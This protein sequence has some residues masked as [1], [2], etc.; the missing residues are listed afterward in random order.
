MAKQS[1]GAK[2]LAVLRMD[3]DNLG[4]LFISGLGHERRTFS[5][6]SV[7]SRN[8][9][10]FF[11]G[12]LNHLWSTRYNNSAYIIY[13]GG[14]DLF[15]VGQWDAIFD[16][17]AQIQKEF[18]RWVC[19]NPSLTISGGISLIGGSFPISKG[20]VFAA[21]AEKKAKEY[22]RP[23]SRGEEPHHN[24]LE[25]N[26]ISLFNKPLGWEK[27]FK[28]VKDMKEEM[29]PLIE[30][31][32]LPRGILQKLMQYAEQAVNQEEKGGSTAWKWRLAYD[33]SRASNRVKDPAAQAFY[34]K[35]KIAAF[36]NKWDGEYLNNF[37]TYSLLHLLEVSA[38]WAELQTK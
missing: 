6:Y 37:T 17:A 31:N 32:K 28:W 35:I 8:L 16:F 26:A 1:T 2:K 18:T 36:E 9:D 33:F 19:E 22:S 14:D 15:I 4:A 12:Y 3:V 38:K 11:K 23:D 21:D 13:S 30:S 27:E 7:L 5:R 25:K 34:N 20:A 24:I 10:Y 29:I